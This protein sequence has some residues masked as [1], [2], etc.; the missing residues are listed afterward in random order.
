MSLNILP[1]DLV[2]EVPQEFDLKE[3]RAYS[4]LNGPQEFTIRTYEGQ[5]K[6]NS[7]ISITAD[8]PSENDLI[9]PVFWKEVEFEFVAKV[10]NGNANATR[11]FTGL[12]GSAAAVPPD[13][14]TG[15]DISHYV[16]PRAFPISQIMATESVSLNG[17][18]FTT[19]LKDYNNCFVR[20]CNDIQDRS[21][22]YS[23]TPSMLDEIHLYSQAEKTFR[24]PFA[25]YAD[26]FIRDSRNAFWGCDYDAIKGSGD[27]SNAANWGSA[28]TIQINANGNK[29]VGFK[30][31]CLEP[32]F[33]SPFWYQKKAL[34]QI[35]S[36]SYNAVI[37]NLGRF[38][39]KNSSPESQTLT[40]LSVSM[41][42]NP[43][44]HFYYASPKL[45]DKIPK[46]LSYSYQEVQVYKQVTGD[47]APGVSGDIVA[48]SINLSSVPR[49]VIIW[50]EE[51][52]SERNGLTVADLQK[53]DT[54]KAR[55]NSINVSFGNRSGLLSSSKDSDL[56]YVSK[57][58]GLDLT[59]SQYSKYVGSAIALDFGREIGLPTD[60][61]VGVLSN[62][63]F[64]ISANITNIS[65]TTNK[66]T[67]KY[68]IIYDGSMSIINGTVSRQLGV[69]SQ[70][71][72][73]ESQLSGAEQ[74]SD[75]KC[76]NLFGGRIAGGFNPLAL[77]PM[78][79]GFVKAIREGIKSPVGQTVLGVADKGLS[80][81]GM[82]K[83]N[84][85]KNKGGRI[86]G[87]RVLSRGDLAN[88]IYHQT[89]EM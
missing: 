84:G 66:Y 81:I 40:E 9:Y 14:Q 13:D 75:D 74:I 70:N 50:A 60:M 19:N 51:S 79:P 29:Y 87:G 71:D 18:Q 21:G 82:G 30:V 48:P 33:V 63:Q 78:V 86:A 47:I 6:S 56:Y 55:I 76:E 32:C 67:L 25:K 34:T 65:S 10:A 8:P 61:S 58:N 89:D 26:S 46:Q 41:S 52:E 59:Y 12:F 24:D 37:T 45:L 31:K 2:N 28:N 64:G 11:G 69:L 5:S 4:V 43:K 22:K 15:K 16:A 38:F 77:L 85:T 80:S 72:V 7:N 42:S 17:A 27:G 54:F 73:L 39:C 49:R 88:S 1:L 83:N 62:P 3:K 53:S 35:K 57:K 23:L 44:L 20:F 36:L 68:A